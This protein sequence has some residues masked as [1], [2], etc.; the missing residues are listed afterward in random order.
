MADLS[1]ERQKGCSGDQIRDHGQ[2]EAERLIALAEQVLPVT[3][4][5]VTFTTN[6]PPPVSL[7]RK[8]W[9]RSLTSDSYSPIRPNCA[10]TAAAT[11]D[12]SRHGGGAEIAKRADEVLAMAGVSPKQADV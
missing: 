5:L 8:F 7:S 4:C 3:G 6:R 11:T 2:G 10:S 1:A 9:S 12:A